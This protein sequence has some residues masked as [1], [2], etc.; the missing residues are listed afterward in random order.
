MRRGA[1]DCEFQGQNMRCK[2]ANADASIIDQDSDHPD[3][4][5]QD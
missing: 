4:S 1:K 3:A 2:N 5:M